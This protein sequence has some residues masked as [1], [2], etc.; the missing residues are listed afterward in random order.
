MNRRLAAFAL[1]LSVVGALAESCG[2]KAVIDTAAGGSDGSG[3][4]ATTTTV[5]QVGPGPITATAVGVGTSGAGGAFNCGDLT[6]A[7]EDIIRTL[8]E[9]DTCDPGPDECG[10]PPGM[11]LTDSC[12]CPVAVN[13]NAE[14]ALDDALEIYR[15]W[16][17]MGC[18]PLDCQEP[19]AVTSDPQCTA[20]GP[21][22][23]GTCNPF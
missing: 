6:A 14:E 19:C 7:L 1:S 10:Y 9:C 17:E 16:L 3:A 2:G 23:A 11:E 20:N 21:T 5:G 8:S 18:G 15:Q 13:I 22:C 4:G 12:G